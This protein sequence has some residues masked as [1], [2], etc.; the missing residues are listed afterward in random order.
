MPPKPN[1]NSAEETLASIDEKISSISQHQDQLQIT[2][3][4]RHE[5]IVSILTTQL[6]I[7]PPPTPP[8]PPFIFSPYFFQTT[9]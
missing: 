9:S 4:S 7:Q 1:S 5:A 6:S 2:M 8:Y 3:N